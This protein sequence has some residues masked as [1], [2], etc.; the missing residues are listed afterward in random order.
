MKKNIYV[1]LIMCL[2][3]LACQQNTQETGD[4]ENSKETSQ[5]NIGDEIEQE[6]KTGVSCF[7]DI[8]NQE[9]TDIDCGGNCKGC[10]E[11][12]QCKKD[13]DC[14]SGY[15]ESGVCKAPSCQDGMKN[16]NEEG[17]DCGGVC[18]PCSKESSQEDE[19]YTLSKEQK[20]NLDDKLTKGTTSEFLVNAHPAGLYVGETIVYAYGITNN[21]YKDTLNFSFSVE[22]VRA[23][24]TTNSPISVNEKTILD[25]FS[26]NDFPVV[27]LGSYEKKMIPVGITVGEYIAPGEETKKGSYYFNLVVKR[28]IGHKWEEYSTDDFSIRVK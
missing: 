17:V 9:E 2:F 1:L 24:D 7:D 8:K 10:K 4:L 28:D 27:E 5:S 11:G 26:K 18:K 16:Q 6:T 21:D 25:W 12:K 23:R 19:E 20:S 13:S 15:C 22:F 3:L 14:L